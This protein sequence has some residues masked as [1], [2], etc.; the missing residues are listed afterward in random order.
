MIQRIKPKLDTFDVSVEWN[1]ADNKWG[2]E[3]MVYLI[4]DNIKPRKL[5]FLSSKSVIGEIF[6]ILVCSPQFLKEPNEEVS[7]DDL[8]KALVMDEYSEIKVEEYLKSRINN[9]GDLSLGE[10]ESEMRQLFNMSD[11]DS[12]S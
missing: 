6:Y 4:D 1:E 2:K 5:P 11:W 10:F 9:L 3:L 8:R 7:S 12:E